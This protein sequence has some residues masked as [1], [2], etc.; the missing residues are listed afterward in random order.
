MQRREFLETF[1]TS[2]DHSNV[3]KKLYFSQIQL[4]FKKEGPSGYWPAIIPEAE[5]CLILCLG[6]TLG[7][8]VESK[9]PG[10]HIA[11]HTHLC[12]CVFAVQLS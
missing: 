9:P 10:V 2:H 12:V 8:F 1:L 3:L 11:L 4:F 5:V 6:T 7:V